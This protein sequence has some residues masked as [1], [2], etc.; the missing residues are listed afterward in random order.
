MTE[1]ATIRE[2]QMVDVSAIMQILLGG[3]LH[4]ES[5]SPDNPELYQKALAEA[6]DGLGTVL[7]A[8]VKGEVVGFGQ[9]LVFR[10]IQNSGGL[11]A[12][13]ES[14]H[15]DERFRS[16]GIGGDLLQSLEAVARDAACYRLQ[17]TSNKGRTD[18]HRF[19]DA[20]GYISSHLG[21]KKTL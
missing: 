6:I 21:F 4:P 7:V 2:A 15:V 19:Y 8:E 5:E 14:L 3:S 12:E 18:A 10:H 13:I 17:L 1:A 16:R 11:C 9:L 20:H